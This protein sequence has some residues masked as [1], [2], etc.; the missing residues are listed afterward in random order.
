[1]WPRWISLFLLTIGSTC[2]GGGQPIRQRDIV[3]QAMHD[4]PSDP[5]LRGT[6]HVPFGYP[7]RA[8][9]AK[10]YVE[11]GG[12]FSPSV[13]S[14]GVSF[15]IT[16]PSGKIIA[17]SDQIPLDQIHQRYLWPVESR[18]TVIAAVEVTTPYYRAVWTTT[19]SQETELALTPFTKP[20]K[21]LQWL[22]AALGRPEVPSLNS[23]GRIMH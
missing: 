5:W 12:S 22:C 8:E 3:L 9:N 23:P 11:P 1:M 10:A 13:P 15:W 20:G 16:D 4:R 14:F 18:S 21:N 6:G 2:A 17:T 7:G 19:P